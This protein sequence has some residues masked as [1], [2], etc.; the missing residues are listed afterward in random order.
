MFC[1]V[2]ES[3]NTGLELFDA[4]Q[5]SL[6]Y[7]VL[8]TQTN[9]D[10]VAEPLLKKL[11][12]Q[13]GVDRLHAN[14]LGVARLTEIAKPLIA[15]SKKK[16]LRFS[17]FK[18]SKPDHALISFFDQVFDSGMNDAVPW[19]HYFTP[20]RYVLLFKVAFL[21][22]D[23]LAKTAWNARREKDSKRCAEMLVDIC[24][25]LL[26]RINQ[27]PDERSQEIISG[28][29]KW[30]IAKPFEISYGVGNYDS[31]LQISPNL[32]GFQQVL[33]SICTESEARQ[34]P[35]KKI[36]VDRQTEFNKAQA[37]LAVWYKNLRGHKTEMGPGMPT[38][39]YTHMPEVPPTFLP[40]D[41]SAGLELVDITLWIAKRIVEDK[42][43][44]PELRELHYVQAKRGRLDEVSLDALDH[45]WKHLLSLPE[46]N[47]PLPAD[48]EKH[49]LE[50]EA[51]RKVQVEA[52]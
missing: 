3:G 5:P 28:A 42:P 4:N 18:V 2:D 52:L 29:L 51:K 41:E 26:D 30:A 40:G 17:F 22:D 43:V 10:L 20:L 19:H 37:E 7:G 16:D 6:Y 35:V 45:R 9:L 14:H 8:C 48:F 33:H 39:D 21:F 44:S 23:D 12:K 46:P 27:L 13:M 47:K 25:Q 36:T 24:T 49:F 50:Q 38:F 15:F 11:R 1:F 34:K 32:I 31:E